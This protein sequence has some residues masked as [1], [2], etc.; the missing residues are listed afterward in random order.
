MNSYITFSKWYKYSFLYPL[1][2]LSICKWNKYSFILTLT[3]SIKQSKVRLQQKG[4][5]Q[6]LNVNLPHPEKWILSLFIS[7]NLFTCTTKGSVTFTIYCTILQEPLSWKLH[8]NKN[9][10]IFFFEMPIFHWAL[11]IGHWILHFGHWSLNLGHCI[12][13]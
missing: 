11:D 7:Q 1:L 5:Y 8:K 6:F 10:E 2:T 4:S 12:A 9:F 3:T 13:H